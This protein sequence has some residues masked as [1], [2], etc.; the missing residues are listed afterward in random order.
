[1]CAGINTRTTI[2]WLKCSRPTAFL[3]SPAVRKCCVCYGTDDYYPDAQIKKLRL[4]P[5]LRCRLSKHSSFEP[6]E[7]QARQGSTVC[8]LPNGSLRLDSTHGI[9]D[10]AQQPVTGSDH[11]R[12]FGGAR[13]ENVSQSQADRRW[14][15]AAFHGCELVVPLKGR[16]P[17]QWNACHAMSPPRGA[18]QRGEK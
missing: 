14:H 7:Q 3:D 13:C 12:L 18:V 6:W 11:G 4:H 8:G 9:G 15:V 1:M 17:A 5:L 10:M 2:P 16:P